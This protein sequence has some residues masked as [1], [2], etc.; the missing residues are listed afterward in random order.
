M[1]S[2][3]LTTYIQSLIIKYGLID[4]GLMLSSTFVDYTINNK[5]I[6]NIR[7]TDYFKYVFDRFKDEF[8]TSNELKLFIE[9]Q[10]QLIINDIE[11]LMIFTFQVELTIN[12]L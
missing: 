8:L 2:I 6:I 3:L 9:E 7:T 10:F 11:K 5:L 1:D 12:G 4:T